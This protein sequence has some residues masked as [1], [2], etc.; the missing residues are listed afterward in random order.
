[1]RKPRS[2]PNL[3]EWVVLAVAAEGSTHGWAVA[4]LLGKGGPLGHAWSSSRPLVYRA[5]ARLIAEGLVRPTGP[6]GGRGPDREPFEITATGRAA[7]EAWLVAPVDH[8]RDLRTEFLVKLLLL[9]R[10]G[11][12]AGPL[13][14]RQRERLDPVA[15]TLAA[16]AAD[17]EGPDRVIAVWRS[18]NAEAAVRFLDALEAGRRDAGGGADEPR[19]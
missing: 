13:V 18:I 15:A 2:E 4:R 16:Q 8:V 17:A 12:D 6:A 14:A 3:T 1:M 7:V 11:A 19:P 9:E 5:V 10:R